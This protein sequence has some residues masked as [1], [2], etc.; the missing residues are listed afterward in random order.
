MKLRASDEDS[1]ELKCAGF[2]M[3]VTLLSVPRILLLD[4]HSAPLTFTR[5]LASHY[6]Y[7]YYDDTYNRG[8]FL[9]E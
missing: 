1:F 2:S 9:I 3:I 5:E 7:F 6:L 8:T 4:Y